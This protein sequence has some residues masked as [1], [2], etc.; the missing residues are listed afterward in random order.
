LGAGESA[1]LEFQYDFSDSQAPAVTQTTVHFQVFAATSDTNIGNN[2]FT[3]TAPLV[4]Q[5]H[6]INFNPNGLVFFHSDQPGVPGCP[7]I[8]FCQGT[9]DPN[10]SVWVPSPQFMAG[11]A[12]YFDSWSDGI[13]D[14]PRTFDAS[15]PLPT[16]SINNHPGSPISV[17]P[18]S[19]DFV[20]MAG[21]S[22]Q[23]RSI[24]LQTAAS[25]QILTLG[26]PADSW[27]SVSGTFNGFQEV[28]VG[29][30]A[31]TGLAPGDYM[32]SFTVVS[33][34]GQAK[35]T[36]QV[37][38]SLR[39]MDRPATI[40]LGGIVNAAS[41]AG[42]PVSATEV[43]SIFGSG[44]GPKGGVAAF[45]PQAGGLPHTL[46][47]TR[48][49]FNG[50]DSELL[51]V[52]DQQISAIVPSSIDSSGS[53]NIEVEL[54]GVAGPTVTLSAASAT[55]GLFTTDASGSGNLAAVN[56]DGTINSPS[57]PAKRGTYVSLFG[58]GFTSGQTEPQNAFGNFLLTFDGN[59][60]GAVSGIVD[61]YVGTEPAEV[62]YAGVVP[63]F[64]LAMQQ[65][66]VLIPADSATGTAVPIRIG[67]VAVGGATGSWAQDG[68]TLAIQ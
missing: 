43:I 20:V 25:G 23:Q 48:V 49:L 51:F 63:G 59:A 65:I 3:L 46:A 54:G 61:A 47:G 8:K 50:V 44:L 45:V 22:P 29:S 5:S 58:T 24:T 33:Q 15:K 36:I 13:T 4:T 38:V 42:G 21:A 41:Y 9:A 19:L 66:N 2:V 27:L 1:S 62:E 18:S 34:I 16:L 10:L 68:A 52:Q 7:N 14:N 37:P 26:S 64:T 6:A 12:W 11:N 67:V 39:I 28:V 53:P 30:V 32:S 55:P 35:Q 31:V 60:L 56:S 57:N 40:N 17:V